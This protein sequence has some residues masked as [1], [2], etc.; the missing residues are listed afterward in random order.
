MAFYVIKMGRLYWSN[1]L[2]FTNLKSATVF[3]D[4]ERCY[5]TLPYPQDRCKWIALDDYRHRKII[6]N[7]LERD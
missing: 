7:R 4:A 5:Y 2:G 1:R 6:K 3:T